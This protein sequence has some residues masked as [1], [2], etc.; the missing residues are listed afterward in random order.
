MVLGETPPGRDCRSE[1]FPRLRPHPTVF[2]EEEGHR[3]SQDSS[4]SEQNFHCSQ[5]RFHGGETNSRSFPPQHIHKAAPLQD[6]NSKGDKTDSP[7]RLLDDLVRSKR[8]LL[9]RS[10]LSLKKTL[11]RFSLGR[12]KLAIQ[13][14]ALRL[15]R[16]SSHL[17]QDHSRSGKDYGKGRN[18][19]SSLPGRPTHHRRNKGG[20]P[21]QDSKSYRHSNLPRVD[22]QREEVPSL[23]S[24]EVHLARS[25]LRSFRPFS[26]D[27]SGDPDFFPIPPNSDS[28]LSVH[29]SEGD[30]ETTGSRELD[31]P[32]R[33]HSQTDSTEN[34][35]DSQIPQRSG[36]RHSYNPEYS[37]EVEH[38]QMDKG[39]PYPTVP[40]LSC[41]QH[42]HSDGC[43]P[44]GLGLP[45]NQELLLR[46]IRQ[47]CSILNKCPGNPDSLVLPSN[48]KGKG[49]SDPDHDGQHFSN[50]SSQEEYFPVLPPFS[51]FRTHLEESNSLPLD[52][53]HLT[54][55]GLLQHHRRSA[56]TSGRTSLGMVTVT[57]G[58]QEDPQT[59]PTAPG[60]SFCNQIEQPTTDVCLPLPG[61]RRGSS[62]CTSN[63]V[64]QMETPLHLPS[65]ELN[66]E[67]HSKDVGLPHRD[68][69][70]SYTRLSQQT[71]VHVSDP[72]EHPFVQHGSHTSTSS[73]RQTDIPISTHK[74]SRVDTIKNS[75]KKR[76]PKCDAIDLM[77]EDLSENTL[78]DYDHKWK[79]FMLFLEEENIPHEEVVVDYALNFLKKLFFKDNL[80][81]STIIKYKTALATPLLAKF[82]INI[83]I[84]EATKLLNA[85][86]RTRPERPSKD[87]HWNLNKVLKFID[88]EIPDS[89]SLSLLLRK[90]AFLLLLA[91]GMRVSEL[92]ACLRTKDCCTF[93]EDNFLQIGHHY[94]FLAKNEKPDKRWSPRIVKPLLM[95]DG[96]PSKLCPV[97][98][99]RSYL[100][101]T[102]NFKKGRIFRS[103]G[104]RSKELTKHQL[105]TEICKLIL[106]ADPGTKA[107]VHDIRSYASSCALAS[108]MITPTELAQAIGWSS[109]AT[110][111]KFYRTAIE[112]L[113]REI[114]WPGPDPRIRRP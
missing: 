67:G 55:S 21:L 35:E 82:N 59:V 70:L 95:E 109:P 32:S 114:S 44:G 49:S 45:S 112:P 80:K 101:R 69:S 106:S 48:G 81:P 11:L 50:L 47:D 113:S 79:T 98:S 19:V 66:R 26:G 12:S 91:T 27:S 85:M 78:R 104:L 57:A 41:S 31:Q 61:R 64:G 2:K 90:T 94:L 20:M 75:F 100:N 3:K 9:A 103:T 46:E 93:T 60:G 68:I 83:K 25:S 88:E 28:F 4:F 18:L 74:A 76:F 52:P 33:P 36:L 42:S 99:L 51:D 105:S 89:P 30:H 62:G 1:I 65:Y 16:S 110:F 8:R 54:H 6:A 97:S 5:K 108:T 92:H 102:S 43:L 96:S 38:L 73:S 84:P 14:D 37:N 7:Q 63:A 40:R 53:L 39:Y 71:M 34:P 107:K 77:L 15:E 56:F 13:S 72:Q 29:L 24:S 86:K 111:Y 17:H 23:T 10:S 58:L 22:S 87:P